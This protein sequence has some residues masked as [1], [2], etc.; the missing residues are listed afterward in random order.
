[1]HSA[2]PNVACRFADKQYKEARLSKSLPKS[3]KFDQ[4]HLTLLLTEIFF[5]RTTAIK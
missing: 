4:K 3:Y 2:L 1:V 5:K